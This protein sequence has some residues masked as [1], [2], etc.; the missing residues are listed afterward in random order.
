[1]QVVGTWQAQQTVAVIASV[2]PLSLSKVSDRF[3]RAAHPPSAA[4][5]SH[6]VHSFLKTANSKPMCETKY[7]TFDLHTM[8]FLY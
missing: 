1:M 5:G 8:Y 4:F 2:L 6:T 3:G 7:I